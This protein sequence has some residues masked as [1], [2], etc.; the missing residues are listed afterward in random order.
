MGIFFFSHQDSSKYLIR[1]TLQESSKYRQN[2]IPDC[3]SWSFSLKIRASTVLADLMG[4]VV[5]EYCS[6]FHCWLHIGWGPMS[7]PSLQF[8]LTSV[9]AV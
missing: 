4:A 3:F 9:F 8:L 5:R 7:C 6:H 2:E 1:V